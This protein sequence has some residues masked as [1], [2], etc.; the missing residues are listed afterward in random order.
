MSC[1]VTNSTVMLVDSKSQVGAIY[2]RMAQHFLQNLHGEEFPRIATFKLN[3]RSLAPHSVANSPKREPP[4]LRS[5]TEP[6]GSP[7]RFQTLNGR[8]A[9]GFPKEATFIEVTKVTRLFFFENQA[10]RPPGFRH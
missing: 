8:A 5:Q 9:K 1:T 3:V 4:S 7:A 6:G 10:V 2:M